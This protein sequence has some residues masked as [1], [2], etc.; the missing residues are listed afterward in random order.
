LEEIL[1]SDGFNTFFNP[2]D[3]TQWSHLTPDIFIQST[4]AELYT[5]LAH[6]KV[7][8][9]LLLEHSDIETP[10][11]GGKYTFKDLCEA[12]IKDIEAIHLAFRTAGAY[13]QAYKEGKLQLPYKD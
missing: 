2:D 3:P 7:I 9:T 6:I 1:V 4:T 5:P 12:G 13:A 11:G 8:L 10:V